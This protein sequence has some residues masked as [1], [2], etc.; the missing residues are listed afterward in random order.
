MAH[1]WSTH[2]SACCVL[3][4]FRMNIESKHNKYATLSQIL[5]RWCNVEFL[6]VLNAIVVIY[7]L[8]MCW[9]YYV[10]L[11][12]STAKRVFATVCNTRYTDKL[13]YEE[14]WFAIVVEKWSVYH[15]AVLSLKRSCAVLPSHFDVYY[16]TNAQSTTVLCYRACDCWI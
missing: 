9:P 14:I 8:T 16:C 15:F 7:M 1:Y 12:F 6:L 3:A 11:L 2:S 13:K 4:N 5:Q 10:V